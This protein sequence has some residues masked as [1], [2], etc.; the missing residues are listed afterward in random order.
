MSSE[1]VPPRLTYEQVGA[2]LGRSRSHIQRLITERHLPAHKSGQ[3]VWF[4]RMEVLRWLAE[5]EKEEADN[6]IQPVRPLGRHGVQHVYPSQTIGGLEHCWCGDVVDHDWPGKTT[7]APHPHDHE[8]T[9][10]V[11]IVQHEQPDEQR[12]IDRKNLKGYHGTLKDFITQCVN[13]DGLRYRS[14]N[15]ET[16]LYPPDDSRPISIYAR[17]NDSQMRSL[18]QWYAAHVEPF[19]ETNM[20]EAVRHLAEVTNDPVEHPSPPDPVPEPN[21]AT[22]STSG[23]WVTYRTDDGEEVPNFETNGTQVRCRLCLGT[24]NEYVS[25]RRTGIGGHNRMLHRDTSNL[26]TPE[27]QAKGLDTRRYNRLRE[28][29]EDAHRMLSLALGLRATDPQQVAALVAETEAL[30]G[31]IAAAEKRADDA[32]AKLTLMREAF[33]GLS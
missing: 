11:V 28:Q 1:P 32:E 8:G 29:V 17:N 6:R 24:E 19:K 14:G 33:E 18:R 13:V 15:S 27:A 31:R 22:G 12:R 3:R 10:Q 25:D 4:D 16:I 9:Q 20:P 21:Q 23:E 30:R 7:G 5:Q 2:W 26:R